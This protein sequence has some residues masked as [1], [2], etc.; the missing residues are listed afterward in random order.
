MYGDIVT[1]LYSR[2]EVSNVA[3]IDMMRNWLAWFSYD[4][5]IE[6]C[7]TSNEFLINTQGS[8]RGLCSADHVPINLVTRENH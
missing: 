7:H 1:G 3:K 8:S 2:S 6:I 4:C 5:N